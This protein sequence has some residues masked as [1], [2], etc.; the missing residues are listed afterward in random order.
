MKFPRKNPHTRT[1]SSA[2]IAEPRSESVAN[3]WPAQYQAW[4]W[5]A[6]K[7]QWVRFGTP[8]ALISEA[9]MFVLDAKERY[10]NCCTAIEWLQG[11]KEK[12]HVEATYSA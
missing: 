4:R 11:K 12:T 3:G 7:Q 1:R 8:C 9:Q 2:A 6:V 10:P 5:K